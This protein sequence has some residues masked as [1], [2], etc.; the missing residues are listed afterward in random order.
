MGNIIVDEA[1]S[2]D[3]F[4]GGIDMDDYGLID[5]DHEDADYKGSDDED[6]S[7]E[8]AEKIDVSDIMTRIS[9]LMVENAVEDLKD[10]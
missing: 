6:L 1:D 5:V 8:S 9:Q 7:D 4:K 10:D 2:L 3:F